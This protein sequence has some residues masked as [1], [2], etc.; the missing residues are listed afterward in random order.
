MTATSTAPLTAS[1]V[2]SAAVQ[3]GVAWGPGRARRTEYGT[4]EGWDGDGDD[5][6]EIIVKI[7]AHCSCGRSCCSGE[8]VFTMIVGWDNI[9]AAFDNENACILPNDEEDYGY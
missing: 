9:V 8:D 3:V 1:E 5:V 4:V 6:S 7:T 2:L